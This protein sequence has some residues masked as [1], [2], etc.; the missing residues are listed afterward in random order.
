MLKIYTSY[1]CVNNTFF[2]KKKYEFLSNYNLSDLK[3]LNYIIIIIIIIIMKYI[4]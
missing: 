3:H 4:Y 2:L 1:F